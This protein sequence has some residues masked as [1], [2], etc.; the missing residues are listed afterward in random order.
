M[1]TMLTTLTTVA[2]ALLLTIN[3]AEAEEK[4]KVFELAESGQTI[5]FPMSVEE[6]AA[7]QAQKGG[8]IAIRGS[9]GKECKSGKKILDR[10]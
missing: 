7:E 2:M 6:I 10:I 3:I 9:K 8:P 1:K 4:V 5:A